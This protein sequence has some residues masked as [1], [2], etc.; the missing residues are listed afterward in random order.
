MPSIRAAPWG[1]RANASVQHAGGADVVDE[2]RVAGQVAAV[3]DPRDRAPDPAPAEGGGFI[4]VH[5]LPAS[6]QRAAD[7]RRRQP[8]AVVGAGVQ[9]MAGV[10]LLRGGPRGR[11]AALRRRP[12][13]A[14]PRAR[15]RERRRRRRARCAASPSS[16]SATAT[17]T[18]A[19][20]PWRRANSWHRGALHGRREAHRGDDLV[21]LERG[22][23]VAEQEVL[24]RDLALAARP[25]DLDHRA[26]RDRDQAPL[27]GRVR[28][29]E[30]AA[31]R[32]AAAD[33]LVADPLRGGAHDLVAALELGGVL[34]L[35]VAWWPRGCAARRCVALDAAQ[36]RRRA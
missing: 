30:A 1:E 20:S 7:Q 31:E 32:A 21:G 28:V 16:G 26:E 24:G 36:L 15:A 5:R 12:A 11:L 10:D 33:R 18:S 3:L 34:D 23:E 4:R 17:A 22:R 9:V 19:K 14:R 13:A 27:G 8:A 25:G 35:G 6:S 29:G 2:V